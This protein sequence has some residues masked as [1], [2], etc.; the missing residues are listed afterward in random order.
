LRTP[1]ATIKFAA[2]YLSETLSASINLDCPDRD[3]ILKVPLT[4]NRTC[5]QANLFIDMQLIK[6]KI[7]YDKFATQVLSI[8]KVISEAIDTYPLQSHQN[9]LI[10]FD[11]SD[12]FT[13]IGNQTYLNHVFYNLLK[14][15]LYFIDNTGK[16]QVFIWLEKNGSTGE[17]HFKDTAKGIPAN[18]L[19]KIFDDFMSSENKHGTGIGL[20]FCKEVIE[21]HS[22][23]IT[24]NSKSGMYTHF[25]ISLPVH[26]N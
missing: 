3:S 8:N 23:T 4:L 17:I 16:G 1:L 2:D 15:S 13:V 14:N 6:T 20:S 18:T 24:C 26:S 5:Q 21:K 10:H 19:P 11:K 25:I 7:D 22:G 12:D 9:H